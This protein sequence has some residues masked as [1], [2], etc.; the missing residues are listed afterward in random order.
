MEYG[1][2]SEILYL[3]K[4]H[5]GTDQLRSVVVNMRKEIIRLGG[6]QDFIQINGFN[7]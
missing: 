4:P 1:A 5:I 6:E 2:P 3:N 7:D